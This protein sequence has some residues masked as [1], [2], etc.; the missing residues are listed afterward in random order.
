[1]WQALAAAALSIWIGRGPY[2]VPVDALAID[3][4]ATY[5]GTYGRGIYLS[6]DRGRSWR[7]LN[8]VSTASAFVYDIAVDSGTLYASTNIGLLRRDGARWTNIGPYA[9]IA[10][11][12][13]RDPTRP[14]TLYSL[15]RPWGVARTTDRGAT[16]DFTAF[17]S[18]YVF[19]LAAAGDTVFA[20]D[21]RGLF[22]STDG[23]ATW[24]L[25]RTES[26]ET[27]VILPGGRVLV[28]LLSGG[29]L[30]SD[31]GGG[32]WQPS[33]SGLTP[34][35][36]ISPA[37]AM[38]VD[39]RDVYLVSNVGGLFRSADGGSSWTEINGGIPGF[40]NAAPN[41]SAFA[42][43]D[44]A[45]AAS[46][47]YG[48]FTSADRGAAWR[49]AAA[50]PSSARVAGVA[51]T[52][53]IVYTSTDLGVFRSDDGGVSWRIAT[54]I[55]YSTVA[56][57]PRDPNT[58][59]AGTAPP[60]H[61]FTS[62]GTISRSTDGGASWQI[63]WTG[64]VGSV[65]TGVA[66][67]GVRAIAAATG[68]LLV[69]GDGGATWTPAASTPP[70]AI[71]SVAIG[72]AL[73]AAGDAGGFASDDGGATWHRIATPLFHVTALAARG[74]LLFAS[75]GTSVALPDGT[76]STAPAKVLSLAASG[77]TLFAGTETAGVF[78]LGL[79]RERATRR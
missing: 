20:A 11:R 5:A 60:F 55:I 40:N 3:G 15:A 63:V 21:V 75:D 61:P 70:G 8:D 79:V 29:I 78:S 14:G 66:T 77:S 54:P 53:A 28:G 32:T 23:G 48:V 76:I 43:A 47:I 2:G 39:G 50:L 12:L 38:R 25:L 10:G 56:V 33:N 73:Y 57:D 37:R 1:M 45:L 62:R 18:P 42:A 36:Q 4:G 22:R 34:P 17:G 58:L 26:V 49:P 35:G 27:I 59:V 41:V 69:S 65:V 6:L 31:D 44:G 7:D 51:A 30:R 71:T 46:V 52:G 74:R 16:W 64:E 13:V 19:A 24:T 72:D 9:D 67:D 68:G